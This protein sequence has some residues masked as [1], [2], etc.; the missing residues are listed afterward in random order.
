M[1]KKTKVST[2]VSWQ[3]A[4]PPQLGT[5]LVPTNQRPFLR[6]ALSPESPLWSETETILQRCLQHK[7]KQLLEP[8]RLLLSRFSCVRLCATP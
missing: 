4:W 7:P 8:L 6:K 5:G 2:A 1:W 3:P